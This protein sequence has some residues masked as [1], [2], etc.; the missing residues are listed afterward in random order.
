MWCRRSKT[1]A[2]KRCRT[3]LGTVPSR[4]CNTT[5][6]VRPQLSACPFLRAVSSG[7]HVS[8]SWLHVC[9]SPLSGMNW[10]RTSAPLLEN[11][12]SCAWVFRDRG[13]GCAIRRRTRCI[14]WNMVDYLNKCVIS[15][16]IWSDLEISCC[17]TAQVAGDFQVWPN[18]VTYHILV[19]VINHIPFNTYC[20]SSYESYHA[21]WAYAFCFGVF[22]LHAF[23]FSW[24]LEVRGT[25]SSFAASISIGG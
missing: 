7:F 14:Q 22:C 15:N 10:W 21:P 2:S 17:L 9:W 1:S 13:S 6:A 5:F 4:G 19:Q 16:M 11:A 12:V 23:L 18:H 20:S 3:R 24:F 8:F 25:D